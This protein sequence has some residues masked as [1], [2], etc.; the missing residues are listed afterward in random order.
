MKHTK[1][2][3]G[4]KPYRI[5]FTADGT[6]TTSHRKLTIITEYGGKH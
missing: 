3:V 4:G 6:K 2:V 1:Y 5:P